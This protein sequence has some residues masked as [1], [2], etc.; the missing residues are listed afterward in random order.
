MSVVG[1]RLPPRYPREVRDL[2]LRW[3]AA[4]AKSN[5]NKHGVSFEEAADALDDIFAISRSDEYHIWKET[6]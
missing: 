1:L 2:Y 3:D 4:K 6:M 5:L